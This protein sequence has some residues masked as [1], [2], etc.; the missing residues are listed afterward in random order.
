MRR[1]FRGI[2][3][4]KSIELDISEI[5]RKC[6]ENKRGSVWS[7]LDTLVSHCDQ[8]G[9][10]DV[11]TTMCRPRTFKITHVLLDVLVRH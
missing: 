2:A 10:K 7:S 6:V 5:F 3:R 11:L 4:W 9:E 8:P 1:F